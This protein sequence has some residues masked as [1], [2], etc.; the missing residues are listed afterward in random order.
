VSTIINP[1]PTSLTLNASRV[2]FNGNNHCSHLNTGG[3]LSRWT[4]KPVYVIWYNAVRA[5]RKMAILPLVKKEG[6]EEEVEEGHGEGIEN[7]DEEEF[8]GM[9]GSLANP[10]IQ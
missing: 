7:E 5:E 3:I 9:S 4:K 10:A 1:D 6:T 2:Y 8:E